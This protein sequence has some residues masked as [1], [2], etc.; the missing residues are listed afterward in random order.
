MSLRP[1][2]GL[3]NSLRLE[4]FVTKVTLRIHPCHPLQAGRLAGIHRMRDLLAGILAQTAIT[5][6][7]RALQVAST[8]HQSRDVYVLSAG[9]INSAFFTA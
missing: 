5:G 7:I 8:I 3:H 9:K 1:P 4:M 2:R 6:K